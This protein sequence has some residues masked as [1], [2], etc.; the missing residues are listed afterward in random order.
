MYHTKIIFIYPTVLLSDWC[1]FNTPPTKQN[2]KPHACND[3]LFNCGRLCKYCGINIDTADLE[4]LKFFH[5]TCWQ[6]YRKHDEVD[7][8]PE[9]LWLL[10]Y[11]NGLISSFY[12]SSARENLRKKLA[13][14]GGVKYGWVF[15]AEVFLCWSP[16]NN[17]EISAIYLWAYNASATFHISFDY[18]TFGCRCYSIVYVF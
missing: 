11:K 2:K 5:G 7:P 8:F 16:C 17:L 12:H 18:L 10:K 1:T 3:N 6:E 14:N 15:L 4:N 13:L 9:N